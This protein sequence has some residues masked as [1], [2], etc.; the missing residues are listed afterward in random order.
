MAGQGINHALNFVEP[1][2]RRLERQAADAEITGHH[3]LA[4]EI[5]ENFQDFFALAEAVEED[6]H[7][8]QVNGVRADPDQMRSAARQ[9]REQHAN[10]LRALGDFDSENFF[11]REAI[12]QVVRKRRKIINAVGEG[13]TLRI[14][15][16]FAGF[17]DAGMQITDN[18]L[19]FYHHF[20]VELQHDPQ[21]S[22]R[23]RVL[24][25]HVQDHGLRGADGS[26]DGGAHR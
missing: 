19:G 1:A 12:A 21:H 7:R 4:G 6:G 20:A 22:V 13:D 9:L 15:L 5:F 26:F 11:H 18:W 17:F 25:P 16:R 3:A 8:A 14:R 2:G 10:V 23:G 24:G